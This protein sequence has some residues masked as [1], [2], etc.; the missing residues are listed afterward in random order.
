MST[1]IYNEKIN[2]KQEEL[3]FKLTI[4]ANIKKNYRQQ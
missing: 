4:L 1:Q 3:S 2:N